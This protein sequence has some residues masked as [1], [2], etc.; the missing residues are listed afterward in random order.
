MNTDSLARVM[1]AVL[2]VMAAGALPERASVQ[3]S[4]AGGRTIPIRGSG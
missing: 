4:A 3:A 2:V 1:P